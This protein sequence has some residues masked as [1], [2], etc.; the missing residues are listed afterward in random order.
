LDVDQLEKREILEWIQANCDFEF[1]KKHRLNSPVNVIL[2]KINKEKMIAI[3][4]DWKQLGL[5]QNEKSDM[6]R[7]YQNV[8]RKIGKNSVLI[9]LHEDSPFELEV[10]C[11]EKDSLINKYDHVISFL[12]GV[13]DVTDQET[14]SMVM[15]CKELNIPIVTC[16]LGKTP[17]FTSKIIYALRC[18]NAFKKLENAVDKLRKKVDSKSEHKEIQNDKVSKTKFCVFLNL[19]FKYNEIS[20]ELADREKFYHMIHLIVCS[21]WRSKVISEANSSVKLETKLFLIFSDGKYLE[22]LQQ[23][24]LEEMS[25]NHR[26]APTEYQI[27]K[28]VMELTLESGKFNFGN[29]INS[30]RKDQMY[31]LDFSRDRIYNNNDVLA[32]PYDENCWCQSSSDEIDKDSSSVVCLLFGSKHNFDLSMIDKSRIILNAFTSK[33]ESFTDGGIVACLQHWDYHGR[34]VP[35]LEKLK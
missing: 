34:L 8:L 27:L 22:L 10:F 4:K 14:K 35:F 3:F 32:S 24:F 20:I 7:L 28:T 15:T 30:E 18:H 6:E 11:K 9:M 25:K 29:V 31:L 23:S 26:A 1:L 13:R 17:E 16:N 12:G 5:N 19:P 2:K 33:M 21:L